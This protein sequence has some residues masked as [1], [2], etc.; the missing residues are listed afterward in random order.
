VFVEGGGQEV[1][2]LATVW[3]GDNVSGICQGV[4]WNRLFVSAVLLKQHG[5]LPE[6]VKLDDVSANLCF[7]EGVILR[8]ICLGGGGVL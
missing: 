7:G 1:G 4:G 6:K 8:C 5:L 3:I 2:C